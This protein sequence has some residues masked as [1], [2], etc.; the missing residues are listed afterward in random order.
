MIEETKQQQEIQ[1]P[2]TS[3][4]II[5]KSCSYTVHTIPHE[6]QKNDAATIDK[7]IRKT[8]ILALKNHRK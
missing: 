1:L 6:V 2:A 3:Q 7:C 5:N 8:K 4:V